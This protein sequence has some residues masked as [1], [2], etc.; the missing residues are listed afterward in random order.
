MPLEHLD[1]EVDLYMMDRR[2]WSRPDRRAV[3]VAVVAARQVWHSI[4]M[5]TPLTCVLGTSSTLIGDWAYM[6]IGVL[7]IAT[8]LVSPNLETTCICARVAFVAQVL[9]AGFLQ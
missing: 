6:N 5:N 7:A 1:D 8:G 3:S 4:T 2:A 9:V